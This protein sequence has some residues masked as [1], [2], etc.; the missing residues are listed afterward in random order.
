[1]AVAFVLIFVL[2]ISIL[3]VYGVYRVKKDRQVKVKEKQLQPVEP[4][5][6]IMARTR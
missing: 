5:V 1:M 3:A 4:L 2:V 6:A